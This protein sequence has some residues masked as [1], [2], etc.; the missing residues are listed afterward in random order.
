MVALAIIMVTILVSGS[1]TAEDLRCDYCGKV[2]TEQYVQDGDK[3][4]HESCYREHVL[5]RCAVCGKPIEGRYTVYD[6]KPYHDSCWKRN[7][8]LR[9]AVC[10]QIIEGD[11][12]IDNWGNHYHSRHQDELPACSFCGRLICMRVTGGGRAYDDRHH[13]CN[14]CREYA[15]TDTYIARRLLDESC[16]RL[17]KVGIEVDCDEVNF[18]LVS[19][20]ELAQ[21]SGSGLA[22]NFGLAHY[23]YET[24]L[25]ITVNRKFT[26]YIRSGM[27]Q[28]HFISTAAHELMH[29]WMYQNGK[30]KVDPPLLEGS[31]NYAALLVLQQYDDDLTAYVIDCLERDPCPVYGDGFR[32]VATFVAEQGKAAWLEY[33]KDHR[34]FPA[35]R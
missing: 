2:I 22:D 3:C 31:C 25:G 23:E 27:P 7:V 15:V 12:L 24:M 5:P 4:Y 33:L 35:G 29:V 28:M 26:V 9:C 32:R 16:D 1:S 8:A 21:L 6:G 19:A 20:E 14:L 18:Q 11:H 13:I 17:K 34:F 10:G 30:D